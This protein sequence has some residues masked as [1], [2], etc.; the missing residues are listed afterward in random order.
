M[1]DLKLLNVQE[2]AELLGISDRSI[3]NRVCPAAKRSF[4]IKPVRVG[5]L[6]RFDLRDIE[7]FIED[8]K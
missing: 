7:R 1:T 3:Y 5:K 8:Q 6:I 2:T 4:P